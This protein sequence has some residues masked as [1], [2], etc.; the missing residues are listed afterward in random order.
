MIVHV[1]SNQKIAV[2]ITLIQDN[3][4]IK[5][6]ALTKLITKER[7]VNKQNLSNHNTDIYIHRI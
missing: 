5:S 3:L 7:L 4:D 2:V 1:N 6:K